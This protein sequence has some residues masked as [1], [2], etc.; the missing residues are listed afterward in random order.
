MTSSRI[1]AATML[2]PDL[3]AIWQIRQGR[4]CS[5]RGA[6][7]MCPCQNVEIGARPAAELPHP[8]SD[9]T[10]AFGWPG[11]DPTEI[12]RQW[13][14]MSAQIKTVHVAGNGHVTTMSDVE[15]VI[16]NLERD[17]G[18]NAR[19]DAVR[20]IRFLAGVNADRMTA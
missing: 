6:D 5:C 1:V 19:D 13:D 20:L 18:A 3:R 9:E 4:V 16:D 10:I 14:L 8:L 17:R 7:D 2:A 15:Q 11:A 12:R